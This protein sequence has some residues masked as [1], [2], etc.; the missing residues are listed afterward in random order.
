MKPT[1]LLL[2]CAFLASCANKQR[3]VYIVT[4]CTKSRQ[5]ASGDGIRVILSDP[6]IYLQ[7]QEIDFEGK[8][9]TVAQDK[10][11]AR[12]ALPEGGQYV[13]NYDT[14]TLLSNP[15]E[16]VR[17]MY[18]GGGSFD[19]PEIDVENWRPS[20]NAKADTIMAHAARARAAARV[21]KEEE[22]KR[23]GRSTA[24]VI[25]PNQ[26]VRIS[27]NATA[28]VT[29]FGE[30]PKRIED[31]RPEDVEYYEINVLKYWRERVEQELENQSRRAGAGYR[32]P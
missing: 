5:E 2:A 31:A 24:Q 21:R 29:L 15:A 25:Y 32:L 10:Y 12:F 18:P 7:Q 27:G 19:I 6:G 28:M 30:A 4:H 16:Y 17:E 1:L 9:I 3:R 20:G 23:S 13:I 22:L 8:E 11:S 26:M 14:D